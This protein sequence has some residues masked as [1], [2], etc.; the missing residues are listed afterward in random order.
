MKKAGVTYAHCIGRVEG[1]RN[2]R[3]HR[4]RKVLLLHDLD[5]P[6]VDSGLHPVDK[7]STD[8][9]RNDIAYPLPRH[10]PEL[11]AVG[12]VVEDL[13]AALQLRDDLLER[14]VLIERHA[15]MSHMTHLDVCRRSTQIIA[16][17]RFFSPLI[18]FFRKYTVTFAYAG[19]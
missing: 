3:V 2:V 4:D 11:L 16:H 15:D 9:R 19:R 5:V 8:D 10:F 12:Q 17:L 18:S 13:G 6:L 14:Q 7:R 1:S